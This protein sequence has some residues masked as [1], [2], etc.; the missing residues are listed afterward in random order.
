M[1]CVRPKNQIQQN[2]KYSTYKIYKIIHSQSKRTHNQFP[3]W[4][5]QQMSPVLLFVFS[6][7]TRLTDSVVLINSKS[8]ALI[9][10]DLSFSQTTSDLNRIDF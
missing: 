8:A 9:N 4:P 5:L 2:I 3:K 10:T 1:Y 6:R 7:L